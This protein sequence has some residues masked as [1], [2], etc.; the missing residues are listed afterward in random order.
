MKCLSGFSLRGS[1]FQ[2]RMEKTFVSFVFSHENNHF[3]PPETDSTT[4]DILSQKHLNSR[5]WQ[6]ALAKKRGERATRHVCI[7]K[8]CVFEECTQTHLSGRWILK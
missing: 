6:C 4:K 1:S 8:M 7:I 3:V 2:E 5:E